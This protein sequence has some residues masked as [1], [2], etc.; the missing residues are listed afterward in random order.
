LESKALALGV[1]LESKAVAKEP[2]HV[3]KAEALD[4]R[5]KVPKAEALESRIKVPKAEALDSSSKLGNREN[6]AWFPH[7]GNSCFYYSP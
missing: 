7:C 6:W 4:S 5:I 1:F 3:P 2:W